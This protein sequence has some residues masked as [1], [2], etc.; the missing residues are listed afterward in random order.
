[1]SRPVNIKF[2]YFT[3][4]RSLFDNTRIIHFFCDSHV[5]TLLVASPTEAQIMICCMVDSKMIQNFVTVLCSFL[6]LTSISHCSTLYSLLGCAG[7]SLSAAAAAETPLTI[8]CR[9]SPLSLLH[10][11][12]GRL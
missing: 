6:D 5:H 4:G 1:M 8:Y 11:L 12:S 2:L 3:L 9:S 7:C 10:M